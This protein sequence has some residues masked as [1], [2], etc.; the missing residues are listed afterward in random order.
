MKTKAAALVVLLSLI[1]ALAGCGAVSRDISGLWYEETGY[2]G[3]I[4]FKSGGAVTY[5]ALD[6][7]YNGKYTFDD[8]KDE[9]KTKINDVEEEFYIK[10]NK[11]MWDG[12]IF[13]R[14]EVDQKTEEDFEQ[15]EKALES[16]GLIG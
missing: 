14:K 15:L 12:S 1:A 16:A 8:E 6:E 5:S 7:T 10:D 2:G 3:T 9:G 11:L 4:E 13:T